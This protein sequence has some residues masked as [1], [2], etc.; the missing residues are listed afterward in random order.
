MCAL[1]C[2]VLVRSGFS[3]LR[4]S[5]CSLIYG[6]TAPFVATPGNGLVCMTPSQELSPSQWPFPFSKTLI[7]WA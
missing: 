6:D 1:A 2:Q 7:N 3:R 4:C 5:L